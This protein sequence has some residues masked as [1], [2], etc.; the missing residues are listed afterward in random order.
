MIMESDFDAI[1]AGI[2]TAPDVNKALR[3]V[4]I[5]GFV[6]V[7]Y[8]KQG[9]DPAII[10]RFADALEQ[11]VNDPGLQADLRNLSYIVDY[12]DTDETKKCL[13]ICTRITR[14]IRT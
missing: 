10:R 3:V 7:Y 14:N 12:H 9:T 5:H 8:T 4:R 13:S 6:F 11:A 1:R 2:K